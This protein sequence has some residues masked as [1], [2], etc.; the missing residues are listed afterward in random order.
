MCSIDL[1][2][3][4]CSAGGVKLSSGS[5]RIT[6]DNSLDERLRLLEDRVCN[7]EHS[8]WSYY[9]VPDVL[10]R[11]CFLKLGMTYSVRT[12]TGNSSRR[13]RRNFR[14]TTGRL[15]E[16]VYV[17]MHNNTGYRIKFTGLNLLAR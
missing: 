1:I 2:L 3:L 4:A 17:P 14:L 8:R 5:R 16:C 9:L 11:R 15:Y 12:R 6:V 10:P 13:W 7:C